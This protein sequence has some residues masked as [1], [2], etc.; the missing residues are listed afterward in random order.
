MEGVSRVLNGG[1]DLPIKEK[2]NC[3]QATVLFFA[4]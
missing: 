3:S 4:F 1:N 2:E